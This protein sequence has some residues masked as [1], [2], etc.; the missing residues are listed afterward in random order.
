MAWIFDN[1][2]MV[3]VA[4]KDLFRIKNRQNIKSRVVS[5]RQWTEG[6]ASVKFCQK[7]FDI[8]NNTVND[9]NNY[10]REV[11]VVCEKMK[12]K[13]IVKILIRNILS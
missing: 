12:I 13:E 9:W 10:L 5:G 3:A 8:S 11:C 6:T 1:F 2:Y 7:H 4:I